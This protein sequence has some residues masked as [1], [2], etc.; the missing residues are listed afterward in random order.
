MSNA[1]IAAADVLEKA[2]AYIEAVEAEK[3]AV[4]VATQAKTAADLKVKFSGLTGGSLTD[5]DAAKLANAAP[6]V[7]ALVEKLAGSLQAADSLG[8]PGETQDT[9]ASPSTTKEAAALAED[10][11]ASWLTNKE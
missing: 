11:F 2:A 9:P 1:L 5:E 8:G 4:A 10:R 7:L 3:Q 6:D